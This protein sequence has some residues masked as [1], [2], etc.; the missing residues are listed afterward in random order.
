M[1]DVACAFARAAVRSKDAQKQLA[2]TSL[3]FLS[4]QT[5][6]QRACLFRCGVGVRSSVLH[7]YTYVRGRIFQNTF[8][9]CLFVLRSAHTMG[10]VPATIPCDKSQR[11]VASCELAIFAS[12]SSRR[13]RLQS[14]RL[15]PGIQTSLNSWDQSQGPSLGPCDQI[16]WQK[17][18]DHTMRLVPAT[19]CRDQSKGLVPS[20]VP[21]LT[22]LNAK[23]PSVYLRKL[24]TGSHLSSLN[25]GVI[26]SHFRFSVMI[27]Q[28]KF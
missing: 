13:D 7:T 1:H 23:T 18:P 2:R 3:S 6:H 21:T 8:F 10:L 4:T 22:H 24:V 12:E 20:C 28:T 25:T 11:L 19:C 15:V 16:L 5:H 26:W 17:W 14:L 9:T 27:L